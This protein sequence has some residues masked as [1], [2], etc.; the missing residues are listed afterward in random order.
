[1]R[2]A[3]HTMVR[4]DRFEE[5]QTARHEVPEELNAALRAAGVCE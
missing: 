1:V 3:L 5:Y 2:I 4:A